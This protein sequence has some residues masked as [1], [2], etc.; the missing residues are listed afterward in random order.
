MRV[1]RER[2]SYA[3]VAATAAL[4][5]ALG[6][7]AYAATLANDSVKSWHIANG[8]VKTWDLQ[9][10]AVEGWKIADGAVGENQLR[11]GGVTEEKLAD[12]VAISGPEGPAG[13][14]GEQGPAGPEGEQGEQGPQG[15]EGPEGPAGTAKAYARVTQTGSVAAG[16]NITDADVVRQDTG[17]YCFRSEVPSYWGAVQVT[18]VLWRPNLTPPALPQ[19]SYNNGGC[20]PEFQGVSVYMW[21]DTDFFGG[22]RVDEA[23]NILFY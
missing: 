8:H 5:I 22:D 14:Q 20:P 23:F 13:P 21:D 11:D 4:F 3:N 9:N 12:G 15:P 6:G 10:H 17:F 7:G 18:P 16:K 1:F 19:V 2:L